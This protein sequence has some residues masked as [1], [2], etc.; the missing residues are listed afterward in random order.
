MNDYGEYIA[1][2]HIRPGMLLRFEPRP[3]PGHVEGERWA[4]M[5]LTWRNPHTKRTGIIKKDELIFVVRMTGAW[6]I[7]IRDN[8]LVEIPA[9]CNLV[10]VK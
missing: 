8:T 5:P 1:F 10:E 7:T 4:Y 6:I 9:P 3:G 2:S